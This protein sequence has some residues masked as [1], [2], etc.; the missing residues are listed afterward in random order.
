MTVLKELKQEANL[1][2][3]ENGAVTNVST[4]SGCLDFFSTA[5]ALRKADEADMIARFINAY[6][7][8]R[9]IA[10]KI[11]FFARDIRGG[12]GERRLFRVILKYLAD[13]DPS[14]VRK[15]LPLISEYGRYDDLL[16]LMGT[17][18]EADAI[19]RIREQLEKDI[20]A[21]KTGETVS[22]IAKWLPSVNT[23]ST[24]QS[25]LGR[26]IA[27]ACGMKESEYRKTLSVLRRELR[28][29]E[30][31]LREKD[32][33]FDYEKQASRALFKYKKAFMRNDGKRYAEFIKAASE[34]TVRLN[35][36][37]IYPYELIDPYIGNYY[38]GSNRCFMRPVSD[39]EK[40]VLNASWAALPDHGSEENALAVVDTS[41]SMYWSG[42]PKPASVALSLGLYFAEHNKGEFA[43]HFIMF[44]ERPQLIELRGETFVDRLRYAA[45]FNEVGNTD[46]EAVFRLVLQTAV[47]NHIPQEEM[48]AKLVIISDMEFD[49]CTE[50][51][52][53]SNF[54]NAKKMYESAGYHLPQ[55]VFW[56]VQSRNRQ[57]PVRF[58]EA[59][60]ALVSGCTPRLFSMTVGEIVDPYTL[61]MNVIGGER[62]ARIA[63]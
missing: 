48:P 28:I 43:D 14:V 17:A 23:S 19:A 60:V 15:N 5:G 27:K 1:N 55:I 24:A 61:M 11:L 16:A 40:D 18:C 39:A 56:N 57:N 54:E 33:T 6:A 52:S 53:L 45:S 21:Q 35:A 50:N 32:Y 13:Q 8:N 47:K 30:N 59:G 36:G 26:K 20:I 12:L 51:A 49:C 44:S 46:I 63:A 22:L 7:E 29:L 31:R 37:N 9:D 4:M 3:T 34:G 62:Y 58:N 38:N 2:Y 41:G 25:A 10:L 42:S